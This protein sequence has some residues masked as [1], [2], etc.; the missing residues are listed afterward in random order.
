MKKTAYLT[1]VNKYDAMYI[2]AVFLFVI[3][4]VYFSNKMIHNTGSIAII[5]YDNKEI[6]TVEL[7][8]NNIIV[9]RKKDYSK[10]LD[11]MEIEIRDNK[12]RVS[13][14]KSPYHYCSM[15]GFINKQTRP[16]ICQPNHV[17]ILIQ[18]NSKSS[19]VDVEVR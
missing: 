17:I 6:M 1:L 3:I 10:L 4:S 11:D 2:I 12:I 15:M 14:E 5:K 18:D 9:L 16:I 7:N 13:K 8:K 19:N